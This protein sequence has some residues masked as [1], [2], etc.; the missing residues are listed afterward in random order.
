MQVKAASIPMPASKSIYEPCTDAW[1]ANHDVVR[2]Q[3]MT[4]AE[5]QA[6]VSVGGNVMCDNQSSAIL[7]ASRFAN[8]YGPEI[9]HNGDPGY[10]MHYHPW[11]KKDDEYNVYGHPH[12]WFLP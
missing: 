4:I 9:H 5:S 6:H 10:Y 3:R 2:G 7:V 8:S 1:I 12:I 11:G